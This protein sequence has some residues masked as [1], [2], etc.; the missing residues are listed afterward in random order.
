MM[1]TKFHQGDPPDIR[2]LRS[3]YRYQQFRARFMRMPENDEC[4]RD[5][6]MRPP[7]FVRNA[8]EEGG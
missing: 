7:S 3:T 4:F 5:S 1:S 8:S 6:F 2:A